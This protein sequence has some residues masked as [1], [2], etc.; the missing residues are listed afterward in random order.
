MKTTSILDRFFASRTILNCDKEPYLKRWYLIRTDRFAIF[1]HK[2]LRSD[3]DRALHDHPWPFIVI[4]IWRGYH[5]ESL[6]GIHR[7]L[8]I[9]GIRKRRATYR[10][11]VILIDGKPSWSIFIRFRKQRVWGFWPESG[12]VDWKQWWHDLCED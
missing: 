7:V 1:V 11:R 8:P 5:E 4:P 9:L 10:H 2:F 3:E 6:K 12:F